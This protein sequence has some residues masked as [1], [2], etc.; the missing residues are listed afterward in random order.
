[1]K[2]KKATYKTLFYIVSISI[3]TIIVILLFINLFL[4]RTKNY[5]SYRES[6]NVDYKVNLKK[7][8]YYQVDRLPSGMTYIANLIDNVE[9]D[10]NYLFDSTKPIDYK[11]S[12]YVDATTR[13]YGDK[14]KETILFEKSEILLDNINVNKKY[15]YNQSINEIIKV[16]YAHFNQFVLDFKSDYALNSDAEVIIA[17][18]V[19]SEGVNNNYGDINLNSKAQIRIPLT[20]QTI[21]IKIEKND[22]NT[23]QIIYEK[24]N[25]NDDNR[26]GIILFII[27]SILDLILVFN[28]FI[29]II[30]YTLRISNYDKEKKKILKE[31]DTI[32]A[33]TT[34]DIDI[35]NYQVINVES[36]L[37]LLD[38]HDN[39]GNPILYYEVLKGKLCYFSIIKDNV[40][41]RYILKRND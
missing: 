30:K 33:N 19:K 32:I 10:F 14:N 3:L 7:N 11:S 17:L 20:L 41:Y 16:D 37:E 35:N 28:L 22:I 2:S 18:H 8:N 40:L 31:Y 6:T 5:L 13:V 4:Y 1:M 36:F 34:S 25:I 39:I 9:I 29:K 21:G 38:I 27:C 24:F 26:F 23:N 15:I 12:Y